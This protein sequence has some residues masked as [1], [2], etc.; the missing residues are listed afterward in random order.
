MAIGEILT[1][2]RPAFIG[3]LMLDCE[4]RSVHTKRATITEHPVER[5]PDVGDNVRPNLDELQITGIVS[6]TPLDDGSEFATFVEEQVRAAVNATSDALDLGLFTREPPPSQRFT[7]RTA[8]RYLREIVS[9]GQPVTIRTNARTYDRM[10]LYNLVQ[11]DEAR[12]GNDYAFEVMA[13][14]LRIVELAFVPEAK[15]AR[16]AKGPKKAAPPPTAAEGEN[17]S[18]LFRIG[19][20]FGWLPTGVQ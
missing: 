7:P 5:G 9:T 15:R 2:V 14:E 6:N 13:R 3:R 10:L 16:V 8:A 12:A 4:I 17:A 18:V 1:G 20:V 19:R 11:T